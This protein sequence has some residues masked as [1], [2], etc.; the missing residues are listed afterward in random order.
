MKFMSDDESNA[1]AAAYSREGDAAT[2]K[3]V[4]IF[5]EPDHRELIDF[6]KAA[7]RRRI[8]GRTDPRPGLCAFDANGMDI[9]EG[10]A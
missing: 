9:I 1:I 6:H 3:P 5:R 4:I 2:D 8:Y 10:R 7:V